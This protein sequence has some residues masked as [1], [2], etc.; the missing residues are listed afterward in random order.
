MINT[1]YRYLILSFDYELFLGKH[2]GTVDK[3][4]LEPTKRIIDLLDE[5]S[6]RHAIFFVDTTYLVRLSE[7]AVIYP[8][9]KLDYENIVFQLQL[10]I[11]KGHYIFP[12][13]HPHWLD[14]IYLKESNT[15]DLSNTDKYRFHNI[16]LEERELIFSQ[17]IEILQR[18]IKPLKPNYFINGFRAGGLS[19]QPFADFKPIFKKHSIKFEFSVLPEVFEIGKIGRS[20]DFRNAPHNYIYKFEDNIIEQQ[21]KGSFYQVPISKVDVSSIGAFFDKLWLK[22]NTVFKQDKSYGNGSG[23]QFSESVDKSNKNFEPA[24][25]E[26]MQINKVWRYKRYL[27]SNACMHFMS[28]PKMLTPVNIDAF[29]R[30][31]S[32]VKKSYFLVTDFKAIKYNKPSILI[33]SY[34]TPPQSGIGGRRWI[35]FAKYLKKAGYRVIMLSADLEDKNLNSPWSEDATGIEIVRLPRKYP[36]ALSGASNKLYDKFDF[37]VSKFLTEQMVEGSIYD[38]AIFWEKQYMKAV[39]EI[40]KRENIN[41]LINTAAPFNLVYYGAKLKTQFPKLKII[42]DLRDPWTW[43]EMY[44]FNNLEVKRRKEEEYKEMYTMQHSDFITC[45]VEP[46]SVFLKQKYPDFIDKVRLLEHGYDLDEVTTLARNRKKDKRLK[47]VF[48]GTLYENTDDELTSLLEFFVQNKNSIEVD[49]YV[50]NNPYIHIF[51]QFKSDNIKLLK[52]LE[53]KL[54]FEKLGDADFYLTISNER[55]KDYLS[56]KFYEI[57]YHKIPI[58]YIGPKSLVSEILMKHGLGI[59]IASDRIKERMAQLLIHPII[60]PSTEPLNI[61]AYEYSQITRKLEEIIAQ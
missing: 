29:S 26:W 19:I 49:F 20:Y 10:L 7:M 28:H 40:V 59:F 56:T 30:F 4:L 16:S 39:A 3:C 5:N 58:L 43:G 9:A 51:N 12:H 45:P 53:S 46:M 27:Q 42:S 8:T 24:S 33:C 22:F 50:S 6:I 61:E 44:G 14:A 1:E 13:L 38:K 55:I 18:I 52:P 25:I 48:G 41:C 11:S 15:W 23:A 57:F 35:K 47:L 31:L 60:L 36:K 37:K 32:H 21:S 17:S 2:S 34:I 54:F